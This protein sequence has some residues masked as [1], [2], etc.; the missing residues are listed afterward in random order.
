M[1]AMLCVLSIMLILLVLPGTVYLGLMTFYGSRK[2]VFPYS[3][4][5]SGRLAIVVPAHNE[6]AG[7][8]RT[9]KNL[10]AL[11]AADEDTVVVVVADNCTDHTAQIAAVCGARVLVRQ[12][13]ALRGKGYALDFAF[14]ALMKE[15]FTAFVVVDADSKAS[16]NF[17]PVLRQHFGRGALAVQ[18]RYTVLNAEA[19]TRTRLSALALLAFNV[20]RPRARHTLGVSAGIFGITMAFSIRKVGRFGPV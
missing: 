9:L 16:P 7:I 5:M 8:A 2:Q 6:V 12:N 10:L 20:L 3:R 1:N 13:D 11:A 15:N 19:S 17:I 14:Q 4:P 18:V